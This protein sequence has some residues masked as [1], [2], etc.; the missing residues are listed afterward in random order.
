[1]NMLYETMRSGLSTVIVVPSSAL[2]SMNLG[3][4]RRHLGAQPAWR[5]M[6]RSPPPAAP[7]GTGLTR[8]QARAR[9]S[10]RALSLESCRASAGS[11]QAQLRDLGAGPKRGNRIEE[12]VSIS[13]T[14][15]NPAR[16]TAWTAADLTRQAGFFE[17]LAFEAALDGFVVCLR[18]S[19]PGRP[20]APRGCRCGGP[21]GRGRASSRISAATPTPKRP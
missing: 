2:D 9:R 3:C 20:R 19:R 17:Q 6:A 13:S 10:R 4:N 12:L 11:T 15:A 18:A 8:P 7:S 5:Q 21:A 14:I 1:M 16:S